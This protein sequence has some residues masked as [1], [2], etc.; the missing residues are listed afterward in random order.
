MADSLPERIRVYSNASGL[1]HITLDSSVSG[2]L[3]FDQ[4]GTGNIPI[5]Y[6]VVCNLD[7]EYGSGLYVSSG[8]YITRNKVISSSNNGEKISL[9]GT[10]VVY[11]AIINDTRFL[12]DQKGVPPSSGYFVTGSGDRF[13]ARQISSIDI[14]G[15]LGYIPYS[16]ENPN[17]YLSELP[18]TVVYTSGEYVD[19]EWITYLNP[20][21][22]ENQYPLWNANKLQGFPISDQAPFPDQVLQW[23]ALNNKW[24]PSTIQT[25]STISSEI[26]NLGHSTIN[27]SISGTLTDTSITSIDSSPLSSGDTI[28]YITKSVY[29]T[30]IQASEIILISDGS[31][32]F[33][34]E[35]GVLY[36]NDK[37]VTFSADM[38]GSDIVLYGQAEN[39]NT[40]I[41]LFK[42]VIN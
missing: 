9:F 26:I 13:I 21:K 42:T 2:Y 24:T 38:S 15:A 20:A 4:I 35:Y 36:N 28:K 29:S 39:A 1:S 32:V 27:G 11:Y 14:S 5:Y 34:S 30:D 12:Y 8:E 25:G 17:L 23:D 41:K 6:G 33:M 40:T 31:N 7:W 10:S 18:E 16:A 19:P 22:V 3:S 37:L